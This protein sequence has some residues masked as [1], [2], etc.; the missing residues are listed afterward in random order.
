MQ[1][2]FDLLPDRSHAASSKSSTGKRS[3]GEEHDLRSLHP[4]EDEKPRLSR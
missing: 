2:R 4:I 1:S 3:G